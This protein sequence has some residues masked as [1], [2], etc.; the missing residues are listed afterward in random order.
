MDTRISALSAKA[1]EM[2]IRSG[3]ADRMA[4]QA[5]GESQAALVRARLARAR[6]VAAQERANAARARWA[7]RH[8]AM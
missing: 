6:A 1:T 7:S 4:N 5:R 3:H 8:R 2:A